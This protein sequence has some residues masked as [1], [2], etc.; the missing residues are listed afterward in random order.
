MK[1]HLNQHLNQ[2]LLAAVCPMLVLLVAGACSGTRKLNYIRTGNADAVL[3]LSSRDRAGAPVSASDSSG[4]TAPADTLKVRDLNGREVFL[5]RAVQDEDGTMIASE[6][7][8]PASVTARFRNVAERMGRIDLHFDINVPAALQDPEW[9]LRFQPRLYLP[10]DTVS[11]AEVRLTGNGYRKTQLRGYE[12]YRKFLAG[13]ITDSSRLHRQRTLERFLARNIPALAALRTDSLPVADST[14]EAIRRSLSGQ[15]GITVAESGKHYR[16]HRLI[17]RNERKMLRRESVFRRLVRNPVA[18][19]PVYLDSLTGEPRDTDIP[20]AYALRTR[21]GLRK[22]DLTLSGEIWSEGRLLYRMPESAPL[23]FYISSI[24]SWTDDAD[25]YVKRIVERKAT[26]RTAAYLDFRQGSAEIDTALHENASELR[27]IEGNIRELWEQDTYE[28]DSLVICATCSPEGSY[29]HNARLAEARSEAI[30]QHFESFLTAE[31]PEPVLRWDLSG[32]PGDE[33]PSV[34][35]PHAVSIQETSVPLQETSVPERFRLT[36]RSIP[37]DWDRLAA[38]VRGDSLLKDR[39]RIL[40]IVTGDETPDRKETELRGTAG[41]PRLFQVLYPLMR[42]VR[43]EFHLHRRGM[44]RDTV[45]TTEID[46]VYRRGVEALR[47]KDYARAITLLRPYRDFNAAIACLSLDYNHTALDILNSL[48]RSPRRDYLLALAY[49]RTGD[50]KRAVNAY[51]E[52]VRADRSL[53][54]RGNLDPEISRLV[55]TYR[56]D[57]LLEDDGAVPPENS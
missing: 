23:T 51:L 40:A 12:Q 8:Q 14:L 48:H 38:L 34:V 39:S 42:T 16:R 35:S 3:S 1:L 28:V 19:G 5:M 44:I 54:F 31:C 13:I 56:L 50:D 10:E 6:V 52:S 17:R 36:A 2:R 57:R 55:H 53:V 30:R 32:T 9:E 25:R 20:Y 27:R 45:H 29:T 37:E 15:Y 7:L 43:F 47:E 24:A 41:Y 4:L 11:L 26:V 46:T 22:A 21:K 49:A 33:T 18:P